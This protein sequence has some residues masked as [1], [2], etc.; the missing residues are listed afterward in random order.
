MNVPSPIPADANLAARYEAK[1]RDLNA[2]QTLDAIRSALRMTVESWLDVA[3]GIRRLE[4]LGVEAD[5]IRSV[6]S[7][8]MLSWMRRI[9][10]GGLC[11]E[12]IVRFHQRAGLITIIGRLA[13]S[14]QLRLGNG[15]RIT[16]VVSDGRGGRTITQALPEEM[17]DP[18]IRQAFAFDHVRSE[19]EQVLWLANRQDVASRPVPEQ[20]GPFKIDKERGLAIFTGKR[21]DAVSATDLAAAAAILRR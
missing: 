1:Y 11:P 14:E 10:S 16:L 15:E 7:G 9:A 20:V 19:S 2:E 3:F 8:P 21:G 18:Q 4:D 6:V 13:P 12:V 17:T 5:R